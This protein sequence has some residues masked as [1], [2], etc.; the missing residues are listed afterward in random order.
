MS[1]NEQDY[2]KILGIDRNA[3]ERDIKKAYRKLAV[4]YHPDRCQDE[5]AS[6]MFK[7]INNAYDILSDSEKRKIYDQYGEKGFKQG[8]GMDDDFMDP[9]DIF[10]RMRPRRPVDQM[11]YTIKLDDYFTKKKVTIPVS[12][13]IKCDECDAT[14]FTD[15]QKHHCNQCGGNGIIVQ[16][17]PVGPGISQQIQMPCPTCKGRKYDV[18]ATNLQCKH[19]TGTGSV[20]KTEMVDVDIP[21]NITTN[22]ITK[23]NGAGSWVDGSYVDLAIIFKLKI[24]KGFGI[25]SDKKLIYTMNINYPETLCGFRRTINHPSGKII[26]VVSE[27]GYVINPD[28]IYHLDMLGLNGEKM[29]L[30]FI[31]NYPE[32]IVMPKNKMLNFNNLDSMMGS[33]YQIDEPSTTNIDSM[34]I[35]ILGRLTKINNNHRSQ[36][37]DDNS[38]GEETMNG[39][40]NCK[41]Q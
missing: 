28:H 32:S 1:D 37:D 30:N 23:L 35:Y 12:R 14:G 29:Y 7:Q 17:I 41:M 19:C 31:I 26:L 8:M 20:K 38:D 21:R 18:N 34:N 40:P 15:K 22:P 13:N 27:K 3:T 5:N 4:K 36:T 25:T 24:P 6:E 11:Q 10:S 39:P 9:M 33:R 16:V 2:Y